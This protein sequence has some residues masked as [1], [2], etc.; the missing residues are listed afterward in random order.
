M[1]D[2]T[3]LLLAIGAMVIYS[4]LLLN[5]NASLLRSDTMQ[6][7]TELE[8]NAIAL[9]QSVIDEV[10]VKPFQ[11]IDLAGLTFGQTL[12]GARIPADADY[13]LGLNPEISWADTTA[14][15]DYETTIQMYYVQKNDPDTPVSPGPTNYQ[16]FDVAVSSKYLS[17]EITLNYIKSRY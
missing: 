1:S 13:A 15:G 9:A 3:D 10:R 12:S 14:Y 17:N 2:Y 16:R 11:D 8:P 6:M 7:E 4:M 5:T